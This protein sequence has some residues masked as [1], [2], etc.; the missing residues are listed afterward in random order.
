MLTKYKLFLLFFICVCS[1]VLGQEFN[2]V[3]RILAPDGTTYNKF[4]ST[5]SIDGNNA[6]VGTNRNGTDEN[7]LNPMQ[8]SGAGYFLKKDETGTWNVVQKVVAS[9]RSSEDGFG[10][11]VAISGRY[12]MLGAPFEENGSGITLRSDHGSVYVFWLNDVGI[13]TEVQKL[14]APWQYTKFGFPIHLDGNRAMIGAREK[15]IL[16]RDEFNQ[17]QLHKDAGAVYVFELQPNG[18]WVLTAEMEASDH[19]SSDNFGKGLNF[20]GDYAVVGCPKKSVKTSFNTEIDNVG[21]VY[22]F[23]KQPDGSWLEVKKMIPSHIASDLSYGE[24]VVISEDQIIVGTQHEAVDNGNGGVA[25]NAG[26]VYVYNK[27]ENKDDWEEVQILKA[28][29]PYQNGIFGDDVLLK[30]STLI[31]GAPRTSIY[32]PEDQTNYAGGV[33]YIFRKDNDGLWQQEQVVKGSSVNSFDY[34]GQHSSFD[35]TTLIIGAQDHIGADNYTSRVGAAFIYELD[36]EPIININVTALRDI[37]END[38]EGEFTFTLSEALISDTEIIF[39][40]SGTATNGTDYDLITHSVTIPSGDTEYTLPISAID[41]AI[42]E[43]GEE[44]ITITLVSASNSVEIG[45]MATANML[46]EDNDSVEAS[47]VAVQTAS[48]AGQEGQFLFR[49]TEAQ[50]TNTEIIYTISGTATNGTDYDV[51]MNTVIIPSG[52]TEFTL[53]ISAIDDA[54]V[55][56]GGEDI[57]ITLE[58]ASND[59]E[60]GS[61]ATANILIEDNDAV[62]ASIVAIQSASEEGQEGQFSF[63][64]TDALATDTEIIFT[65]LGTAINGTDYDEIINTVTIPSGETE[66]V[67]LIS[68]ID[69]AIVEVGGEDITITIESVS[70]N[71]QIESN[72]T[73]N[74]FLEDN[75]DEDVIIEASIV[76]TENAGETSTSGSFT[77]SISKAMQESTEI[78]YLISGNAEEG[79]DFSSLSG[80]VTIPLNTTSVTIPITVI[81]DNIV[82]I[83]SEQLSISLISAN[84][85]VIIGNENI[86]TMSIED[87]DISEVNIIGITDASENNVLGVFEITLTKPINQEVSISYVLKGSAELDI[88]YTIESSVFMI[89][90]NTTNFSLIINPID[91]TFEEIGGEEIIIDLVSEQEYLNLGLNWKGSIQILDNDIAKSKQPLVF[92]E[93]IVYP[94]PSYGAFTIDFGVEGTKGAVI[95]IFDISNKRVYS[96]ILTEGQTTLSIEGIISH[97]AYTLKILNN[98]RKITKRVIRL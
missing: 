30:N 96:E 52:E 53:L 75:D 86:A 60:I 76:V 15:T 41:D 12:A 92:Q 24:S 32:N 27:K 5:V 68:A 25:Q 17:S 70:N 66:F 4:G 45:T 35:G 49:L 2:E 88:D 77:I 26:V 42:V 44:D 67:L 58:S 47:I 48:E 94:N 11:M 87:N 59:V 78:V 91:D 39:A 90:V 19:E 46:I 57:A 54:N 28:D 1:F 18:E 82:E 40:I 8:K 89:P 29:S 51:I 43:G 55:E 62:E 74:I 85:N 98:G 14:E 64:L 84:N 61:T 23:K 21:A 20:Y 69:D 38:T 34:F 13:W 93:P 97:G 71:V 95:E 72:A 50:L 80:S 16:Y 65:I 73:A 9:D 37:S 3:A 33:S 36:G 6:V 79:I 63:S 31:V 10:T 7:G 81:D 22:V 83:S 56:V